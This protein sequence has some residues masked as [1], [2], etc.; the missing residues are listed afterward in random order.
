MI[1]ILRNMLYICIVLEITTAVKLQK[2]RDLNNINIA[3]MDFTKIIEGTD[4][5]GNVF[6]YEINGK[7]YSIQGELYY[8]KKKE[9]YEHIHVGPRGG[10]YLIWWK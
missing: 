2:N 3:I 6:E 8:N 9:R 10:E 7:Q 4:H 1:C 5:W